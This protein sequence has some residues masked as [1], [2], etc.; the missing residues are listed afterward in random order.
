MWLCQTMK[1]TLLLKS[2]RE[3]CSQWYLGIGNETV[4]F[5][6]RLF[7]NIN[8]FL[9]FTRPFY[10]LQNFVGS[11]LLN[12]IVCLTCITLFLLFLWF[13]KVMLLTYDSS[14]P[15]SNCCC[16]PLWVG[17]RGSGLV[18]GVWHGCLVVLACVTW[19]NTN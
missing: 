18:L 15:I 5:K 3:G 2:T 19:K 12:S 7:P 13:K 10:S 11:T 1:N 9:F 16:G 17:V 14:R 6:Y 4:P 8:S